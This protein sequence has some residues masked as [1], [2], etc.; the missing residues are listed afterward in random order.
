MI[1]GGRKEG[2]G[3]GWVR[4]KNREMINFKHY[5]HHGEIGCLFQSK[6]VSRG[7]VDTKQCTNISCMSLRHFL[8]LVTV[9]AD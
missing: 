7:T 5:P 9:H 3:Q 4:E 1:E 8:H 6:G 2:R